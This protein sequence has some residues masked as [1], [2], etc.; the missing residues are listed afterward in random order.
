MADDLRAEAARCVEVLQRWYRADR[1]ANATGLYR[2][3]DPGIRGARKR[4]LQAAGRLND[5][6]DTQRWWN[7]ANAIAALIGYISAAPDDSYRPCVAYTFEHATRAYSI[8]AARLI[9]TAS[10]GAAAGAGLGIA[11]SSLRRLPGLGRLGGQPRSA[12]KH[13]LGGSA[14]GGAAGLLAGGAGSAAAGARI[15]YRDFIGDFYDDMAWWALAWIAAYDLTGEHRYRQAARRI[16]DEMTLGWDS[17]WGGGVYW[18]QDRQG[19]G[20]WP[21]SV[22]K[23]AITNEQF[24]AIAAALALRADSPAGG[25][26]LAEWA[27][28][29]WT[30]F[31]SAPP[32]GV[33][34]INDQNLVN[35][36][37][38]ADGQNDDT[39]AIWSYNQGVILGALCDLGQL[40]G[41]ES[42]LARAESIADAF[43]V[44]PVRNAGVAP[45]PD[46]SGV[47]EGI[48]HERTDSDA[49]G[50]QPPPS[51]VPIDGAQF[52]GIF[53]RNLAKLY[54]RTRKPAYQE[55][56]LRNAETAISFAEDGA[57]G[58]NW[59]ARPDDSDFIRQSAALDLLNAALIA[60]DAP[61]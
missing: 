48:L 2:Y 45:P 29:G 7:N 52:K 36:S 5:T 9:A 41:E 32:R 58:A 8:N 31:S 20:G 22:Y 28:R 33:A 10:A 60:T 34:M 44:T 25:E 19:P 3:E 1:Y 13:R 15:Y 47:I 4:A 16:F 61:A 38:N 40:T 35:D 59:A 39:H 56:I 42:Y 46:A 18:R 43:I 17:V 14:I 55:F 49:T 26:E 27:M 21:G 53:V 37:P 57:Y 51:P 54:V 50:A 6:Q 24:I 11:L 23:N 30:W 12:G